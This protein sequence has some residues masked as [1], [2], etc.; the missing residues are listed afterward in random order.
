MLAHA[1]RRPQ[2]GCG[3]ALGFAS[4]IACTRVPNSEPPKSATSS[5]ATSS[6]VPAAPANPIVAITSRAFH[7][8]G[9]RQAGDVVCWGKNTYGQL[10]NR[11]RQD[12]VRHVAVANLTRATAVAVGLDFSCAILQG[13]Q[14]M[15]WGN[16][17]DGQLGDGR[18][19]Q[20]GSLSLRPVPVANLQAVEEISLGEYHACAR[21]RSG[22]VKCWGNAGNGQIGSDQQRAFGMPRTIGYLG[23]VQQIASGASHVC[24]LEISGGV[25]CWGR[26]TEG[27][28]GTGR[29][30]SRIA[31]K[32]VV[33]LE[34]AVAIAAGSHHTCA[35]RRGG[36]VWC[37]GD[38]SAAQLGP[39]AGRER[40]R[41]IP[42]AL[43]GLK[44]VAALAG[45]DK[46]TCARLQAGRMVCWGANEHAQLGHKAAPTHRASPTPVGRVVGALDMALGAAHTCALL[47]RGEVVCW[48][49]ADYGALGPRRLI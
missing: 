20:P 39:G 43:D 8:C 32:A 10:G 28:L 13:G 37:W 33:G 22:A 24:A 16:N 23:K 3:L 41:D 46:H 9:V 19:P 34:D 21:E 31:P 11:L 42:V 17:E 15:C 44:E 12:S 2:I 48:G 47:Q 1:M 18:G 14:V 6:Q 35:V 7:T 45:G 26:N 36:S 29:S 27:Q 5:G 25:K 49:Q 4:L 30:G 40:K 38:N